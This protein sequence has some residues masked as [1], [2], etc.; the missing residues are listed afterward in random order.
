MQE[1]VAQEAYGKAQETA[2]IS[3]LQ[4]GVRVK[5]MRAREEFLSLSA[6]A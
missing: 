2:H 1:S 6:F 5:I 4:A 3:F